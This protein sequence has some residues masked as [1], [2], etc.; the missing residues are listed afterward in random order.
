VSSG[1][2]D[3]LAQPVELCFK[4]NNDVLLLAQ[5]AAAQYATQTFSLVCFSVEL[6]YSFVCGLAEQADRAELKGQ[7]QRIGRQN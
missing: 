5:S 6:A 3:G 4:Q 7:H 2:Q 1:H